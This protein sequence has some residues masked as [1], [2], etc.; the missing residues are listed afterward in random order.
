MFPPKRTMTWS[1][2]LDLLKEAERMHRQM[3]APR[4]PS[5]HRPAWEPPVD[6]I[7]T[8]REVLIYAALPGADPQSVVVRIEDG[9]LVLA[10]ERK[11]PAEFRAALIH[12]LELPQGAFLRRVPLP[13]GRYDSV[14]MA[15]ADNCLV[16]RLSK[17]SQA[18]P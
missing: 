17:A 11:L 16:I 5:A 13:S 3:F 6:V 2:A 14:S 7:E 9:E 10:G 12:R 18:K 8:E 15:H 1:E 4:A